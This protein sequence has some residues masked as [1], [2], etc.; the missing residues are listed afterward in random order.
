MYMREIQS[1]R[2]GSLEH[3]KFLCPSS[4]SRRI[5]LNMGMHMPG[6][7]D[8]RGLDKDAN[9][10]EEGIRSTCADIARLVQR[11]V[12][13]CKIPSERIVLAGFSQGGSIAITA[14]LSFMDH[15]LAGIA[16]LST[17]LS[18]GKQLDGLMRDANLRTP[19]LM[20]HGDSDG[21]VDMKWGRLSHERIVEAR[22]KRGVEDADSLTEFR[23]Y[24]GLEHTSCPEEIGDFMDFLQRVVPAEYS[25]GE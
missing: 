11:E 24:R 16:G 18:L 10:D 6:W 14:S 5:T 20:I 17:Y 13:D 8:I 4:A 19:M 23:V 3:I 2:G 25:K 12:D 7:Y 9:E 1:Q 15:T 22:K 21:V